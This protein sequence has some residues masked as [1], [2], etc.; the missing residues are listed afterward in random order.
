MRD[1]EEGFI[2][3]EKFST[4][5][6]RMPDCMKGYNSKRLFFMMLAFKF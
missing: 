1:N 6:N 2:H 3:G 5:R 4:Y